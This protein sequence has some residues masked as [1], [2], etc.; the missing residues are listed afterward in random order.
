[1]TDKPKIPKEI[2]DKIM[3][4]PDDLRPNKPF[5]TDGCSGRMSWAWR[6]FLGEAPPWEGCC[7][8]HDFAYWKGGC[9][10][11]KFDV[12]IELAR[13]VWKGG[14]PVWAVLMFLAVTIYG[15]KWLPTSFRWGYGWKYPYACNHKHLDK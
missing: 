15:V 10:K 3:A 2:L 9:W 7:V 1:M 4:M 8:L 12:D 6:R 13:C 14:H 5:K 11:T